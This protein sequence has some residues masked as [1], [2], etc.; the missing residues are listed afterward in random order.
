M[1]S[2]A[3]RQFWT[4]YSRLTAAAQDAADK[5]LELFEADPFHRSLQFKHLRSSIWSA[6]VTGGYRASGIRRGDLIVWVWIGTHA[7]YDKLI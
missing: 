3:T 7:D 2:K 6:R 4:L 5:Q 1:K